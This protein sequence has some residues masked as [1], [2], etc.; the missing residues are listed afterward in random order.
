MKVFFC[1]FFSGERKRVISL[2]RTVAIPILYDAA[3]KES[4][5]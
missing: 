5:I 4:I 1:V 3:G 2:A